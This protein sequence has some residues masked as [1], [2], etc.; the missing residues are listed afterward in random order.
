MDRFVKIYDW[1]LELGL[2]PGELIAFAIV[3]SFWTKYGDWFRGS[4]SFVA[5]WMGVKDR[6]TA[7]TALSS[8]VDKGLVE[9]RERWEKGQKLCDYKPCEK[10]TRPMPKNHTGAV[11]KNRLQTERPETDRETIKEINNKEIH[12]SVEEFRKEHRK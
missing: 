9:K 4:A 7:I 6:H 12:L 2:K 3:H 11:S 8:I 1:M 5:K 10:F